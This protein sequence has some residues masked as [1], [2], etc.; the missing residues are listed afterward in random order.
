MY[1][2][3]H[4]LKIVLFRVP[5]RIVFFEPRLRLESQLAKVREQCWPLI[6]INEAAINDKA[7]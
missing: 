3:D 5:S 4:T 2:M 6:H 7:V 1:R